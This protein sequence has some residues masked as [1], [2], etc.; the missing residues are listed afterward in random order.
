MTLLNNISPNVSKNLFA[1]FLLV[2]ANCFR[3]LKLPAPSSSQIIETVGAGKTRAYKLTSTV[4][5]SIEGLSR[6]AGRPS[7][8]KPEAHQDTGHISRRVVEYIMDNAGCVSMS[9]KQRRRYSDEFRCFIVNLWEKEK[10]KKEEK[11]NIDTATFAHAAQIPEGTFR[12]WIGSIQENTS[13]NP[14]ME[15]ISE[16]QNSDCEE[17]DSS[18]R[19]QSLAQIET[20]LNAWKNWHGDFSPFCEHVEKH[21]RLPF[22]RTM[23]AGIL[24]KCGER[25]PERRSGR[26][27]DEKALRNSF[28]TF[29]PGAQWTGDGTQVSIEIGS[30][31]FTFNFEL[32]VDTSSS[33][34][35]GASVRDE[36]DSDAVIEAFK[37]GEKSTG[38]NPLCLLVDLKPCNHTPEVKEEIGETML[39]PSTKGRAQNKAHVEGAFGLMKKT[40][41]DLKI[42]ASSKKELAQQIAALLV[43][44]WARTLNHKPRP[45]R[46]NLSRAEQYN[47]AAPTEQQVKD[48][49]KLLEQRVEKQ[50]KANETLRARQDPVKIQMLS[51]AFER[52]GLIDPNGNLISSIARY[53]LDAILSGIATFEGKKN[54]GTL[55]EDVDGR[56]LLG[57]VKNISQTHEGMFTAEILLKERLKAKDCLLAELQSQLEGLKRFQKSPHHLVN[58]LIKKAL[59]TER[60]I[61]RIFWLS[62]VSDILSGL[63]LSERKSLYENACR[64]I[65]SAF[66]IHY[67]ERCKI[68]SFLASK[69]VKLR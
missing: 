57:I 29:F 37:D 22:K 41:P 50:R 59:E 13:E 18:A 60:F 49:K 2:A 34:L 26:S 31:T 67:K 9:G 40:L 30:S 47:A 48:A 10:E 65:H 20:L 33:A 45:Q 38:G 1:A 46:G 21:L 66:K 14:E 7:N 17:L 36:E 69:V 11:E 6:T 55:P 64:R 28:E 23:I 39:M 19:K 24:E 16:Q 44:T 68:V 8:Q 4:E 63:P 27:P 58:S 56:Y 61:D 42:N 52:F 35:V 5:Q 62:S 53:P 15:S 3:K 12:Q 51:D 32:M 54:S 25:I 43:I